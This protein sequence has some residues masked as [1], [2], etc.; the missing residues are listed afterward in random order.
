MPIGLDGHSVNSD[1]CSRLADAE[2]PC[3]PI[4]ARRDITGRGGQGGGEDGADRQ[5]GKK[6]LHGILHSLA[7]IMRTW[8]GACRVKQVASP[9]RGTV[10]DDATGQ[11]AG[12]LN[13]GSATRADRYE[14]TLI[15]HSSVRSNQRSYTFLVCTPKVLK[16]FGR[17]YEISTIENTLFGTI[18][19]NGFA[20]GGARGRRPWV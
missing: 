9:R 20:V 12:S 19:L 7:G 11:L 14:V 15:R 2:R 5:Q 4:G 17:S 16:Q 8:R 6:R 10:A 3:H 18:G 13:L 1:R